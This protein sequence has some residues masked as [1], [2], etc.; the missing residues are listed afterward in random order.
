MVYVY[1]KTYRVSRADKFITF[2][3]FWVFGLITLTINTVFDVWYFLKHLWLTDLPKTQHKT[4]HEQISK[5]NIERLVNFFKPKQEKILS[6]KD[7]AT[8]I[9]NEFG[10]F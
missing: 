7:V 2:I 3:F 10:V 1:S 5:K 8:D 6:Y 9:R 4:S